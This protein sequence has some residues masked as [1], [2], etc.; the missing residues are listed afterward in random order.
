MSVPVTRNPS[1]SLRRIYVRRSVRTRVSTVRIWEDAQRYVS[2][3]DEP[4]GSPET[5]VR[6][7]SWKRPRRKRE[8]LRRGEGGRGTGRKSE[9]GVRAIMT[10]R[11]R[12]YLPRWR[13]GKGKEQT[14][15]G[16]EQTSKRQTKGV[17]LFLDTPETKHVPT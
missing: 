11:G 15:G 7:E 9:D 8:T 16:K 10:R 3:K 5:P 4:G 14:E 2:L 13:S 12:V 6:T 17:I 1:T